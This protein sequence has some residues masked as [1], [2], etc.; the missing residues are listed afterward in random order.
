MKQLKNNYKTIAFCCC[1][2]LSTLQSAYAFDLIN[3]ENNSL[4]ANL[5]LAAGA[6]YSDKNY[7]YDSDRN[8]AHWLEGYAK[9]GLSG[10]HKINSD[11]AVYGAL[12]GIT[13]GTFADGD[14]AG[15]TTGKERDTDLEELFIGVKYKNLDLS[16]GRQS[17]II[18][19]GFLING[20]A[21]NLGQGLSDDDFDF[22]RGGAYWLAAKKAFDQTF[23]AKLGAEQGFRSDV[24]WL[25]SDNKAQA[26]IELA[27]LNLEYV[28][29]YG[30]FGLM[31]LKGLDVNRAY[32][33]ALGLTY[34]DGQKTT[35]I[36][37]QGSAGVDP[38]FL[39]AEFVT[40]EQGDATG[41]NANAWYLEA[42]WTFD[43]VVWSPSINVRYT[44]LEAGYDPLFFGFNRGYGTWFQGEVAANY[45][46]LFGSDT[47]I[48]H[49]GIKA[50][51]TAN[52]SVGAVFF[53][54]TKT[55]HKSGSLDSQEL[56]FYVEWAVNDNLMI[57]PVIGF[58]KPEHSARTGGSQLNDSQLN[59]YAQVIAV[60]SF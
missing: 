23:V 20:D 36:R 26:E 41:K 59:T 6:F 56:D 51:P 7:L 52:V 24:F 8:G 13:S 42:G 37:Y 53:N 27:G 5:E 58:F 55:A 15:F 49:V 28:A 21:L 38:L 40:Q 12:S 16:V 31:H 60:A 35:S 29:D 18:G 32:A 47:D 3:T 57:S 33:Q 17:L 39:S 9:Y 50:Q 11:A 43:K 34:R 2:S 54:F 1:A 25:K 22:D 45:A 14:A 48:F 10:Q 4:N 46:G 44:A 19:D 30:T